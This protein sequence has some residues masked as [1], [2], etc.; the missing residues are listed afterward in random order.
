MQPEHAGT[1]GWAGLVAGIVAWDLIAPET[2]SHAG[3][4]ALEHP[5]YK[6]LYVGA[7]GATALH[8]LDLYP[9]GRDPFKTSLER[10]KR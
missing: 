10:I 6:Y 4:R 3:R 5:I 9:E 1:W 7:I 2:L 8:L